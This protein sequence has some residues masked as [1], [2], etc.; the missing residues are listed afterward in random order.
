VPFLSTLLFAFGGHPSLVDLQ[1]G[2]IV[3]CAIA[4]GMPS[5]RA[6]EAELPMRVFVEDLNDA[7]P[8]MRALKAI[9]L[10][11]F[12][13]AGTHPQLLHWCCRLSFMTSQDL[14]T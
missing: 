3:G 4:S 7:R 2:H 1:G 9:M 8:D 11:P 14:F 13:M 6:V 12:L 10:G 5:I